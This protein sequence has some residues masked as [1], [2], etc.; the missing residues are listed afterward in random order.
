M[1][2]LLTRTF[3]FLI[4]AGPCYPIV[5]HSPAPPIFRLHAV[6]IESTGALPARDLFVDA[7]GIL[8][9]KASA[10][11]HALQ[12]AVT[13]ADGGVMPASRVAHVTMGAMRTDPDNLA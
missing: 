6:S 5:G 12:T 7:A 4:H 3:L 10:L 11:K 8:A 1:L 2:L 9:S 13:Q